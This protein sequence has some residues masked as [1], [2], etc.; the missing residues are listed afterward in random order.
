M[1]GQE[2]GVLEG[3]LMGEDCGMMNGRKLSNYV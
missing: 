1:C 2:K 3:G